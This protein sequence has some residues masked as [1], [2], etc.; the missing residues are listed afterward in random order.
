MAANLRKS[1]RVRVQP[2]TLDPH[3]DR[4]ASDACVGRKQVNYLMD[5]SLIEEAVVLIV[6]PSVAANRWRFNIYQ[7]VDIDQ[8]DL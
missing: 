6:L 8:A 3:A 4:P 2:D 1:G 7:L 5:T